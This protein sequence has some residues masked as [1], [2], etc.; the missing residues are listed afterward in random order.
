MHVKEEVPRRWD[1][2]GKGRMSRAQP[3]R[4]GHCERGR[5]GSLGASPQREV[6]RAL[7][8]RH[9]NRGVGRNHR[10]G[11]AGWRPWVA[12]ASEAWTGRGGRGAAPRWGDGVGPVAL[13]DGHRGGGRVWGVSKGNRGRRRWAGR[14]NELWALGSGRVGGCRPCRETRR[15][16][17]GCIQSHRVRT[18]TSIQTVDNSDEKRVHGKMCMGGGGTK[19][20]FRTSHPLGQE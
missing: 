12:E 6:L 9:W 7:W 8:G 3:D 16:R 2:G 17:L 4:R 15:S 19:R 11:R 14:D 10:P 13:G 1:P 18:T 5:T 20:Q